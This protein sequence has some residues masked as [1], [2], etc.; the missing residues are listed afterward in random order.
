MV[1]TTL[2][3][4][5]SASCLPKLSRLCGNTAF[6]TTSTKQADSSDDN[7]QESAGHASPSV[8]SRGAD[9]HAA[10]STNGGPLVSKINNSENLSGIFGGVRKFSTLPSTNDSDKIHKAKSSNSS[11]KA[12]AQTVDKAE[13]LLSPIDR[14]KT[15]IGAASPV[16]PNDNISDRN[17]REKKINLAEAK[18]SKQDATK[19]NQKVSKARL[20]TDRPIGSDVMFQVGL[21]ITYAQLCKIIL[22]PLIFELLIVMQVNAVINF[23]VLENIFIIILGNL[24]QLHSKAKER[25]VPESRVGRIMSFGSMYI[26][27]VY[28]NL[29]CLKKI[30]QVQRG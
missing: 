4:V 17:S 6:C 14:V 12:A 20:Q 11:S 9:Q 22:Q 29:T 3:R 27:H 2:A 16:K 19:L 13:E 23:H 8:S 21:C 10:S 30:K 25:K 24:F 5:L 1:G 28:N 18:H 26:K 15:S 7:H